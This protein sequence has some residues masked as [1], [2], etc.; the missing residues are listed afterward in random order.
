MLP[1]ALIL[2]S[3][4]SASAQTARLWPALAAQ[5]P[6]EA[7][8]NSPG[9]WRD[10]RFYLY[11][12][13][14]NPIRTS[15]LDPLRLGSAR[16]VLFDDYA[17]QHR[18]I[19]ATWIDEDGTVFGWYHHEPGDVCGDAPRTSPLI[20]ALVSYDGG[21]SFF[22]L[23]IVLS[24][25]APPVCDAQNGYFAGGHGDFTVI[26]DRN[27]EYFY[28]LFSNYGGETAEQGVAIARMPFADRLRPAGTVWKFFDTGWDEPGVGGRVT[29]IFP[30]TSWVD[31]FTDAFWGPSIHWNTYLNKWVILMNR[32]CCEPGWPQEGI[33]IA[34]NEDLSNPRSWSKPQKLL[35]GGA[36][37]PQVIG[38]GPGE[39]DKEAG[40]RSRLFIG[41]E[42][43]F[44]LVF[45]EP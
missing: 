3:V 33:Y 15:G 30:A 29:P 9:H 19:E 20:G 7:D 36:W 22:D 5:M 10:G 31:S 23:G 28:F 17:R 34:Y 38:L 2:V 25:G 21:S 26:L 13:N 24:S 42:S 8:S 27:R 32:S 40:E 45:T 11:N 14:G 18:W 41:G 37:Y 43:R 35:P 1:L 44:E 12:S 39:S 6:G 16:A 4:L